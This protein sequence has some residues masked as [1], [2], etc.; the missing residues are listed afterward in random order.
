MPKSL[1]NQEKRVHVAI[2]IRV[3]YWDGAVRSAQE[4]AC[5]YDIDMQGA[6]VAGLRNVREVGEI[7]TVERGRNK[8]LFRVSW[9]GNPESEL[10]GQFGI[11]CI[12]EDKVPWLAELQ[13]MEEIYNPITQRSFKF[14]S[15]LSPMAG[16]NRRRAP[17]YAAA[18]IADVFKNRG[19]T[20]MRADIRN[21]S[22]RGCLLDVPKPVLPGSEV[23]LNLPVLDCELTIQGQVRFTAHNLGSGIEFRQIRQGDRPLLHLL[24]RQLA[25]HTRELDAWNF[26]EVVRA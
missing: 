4:L 1:A 25:E 14:T 16:A 24:L 5:T 13:E 15:R 19:C 10:R 18:G 11:E 3:S 22:E 23:H 8:A 12:E 17:R 26:E 9:I 2:P 21:L 6:R 7:V 20:P